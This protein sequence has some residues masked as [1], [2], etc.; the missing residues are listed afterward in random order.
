MNKFLSNL[1]EG[2][3]S[4]RVFFVSKNYTF[5]GK[6]TYNYS[7]MYASYVGEHIEFFTDNDV[8]TTLVGVCDVS[9][10]GAVVFT[11]H[12]NAKGVEVVDSKKNS[13]FKMS[14]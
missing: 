10:I 12:E 9:D 11:K 8:D 3:C 6:D 14:Y 5:A 13:I 7:T 2:E 4:P 1:F